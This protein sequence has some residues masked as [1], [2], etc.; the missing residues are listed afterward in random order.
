MRLAL[1]QIRGD[2]VYDYADTAKKNLTLIEKACA[3]KPDF[4]V[5]PECAYPSY[6][7]GPEK[8][9]LKEAVAG[10]EALLEEV[11]KLAKLRRVYI[12]IGIAVERE[13]RLYNAAVT[14][15][16]E[17][18]EIDFAAKTNLWHFDDRWFSPGQGYSAF[19]TE[20]G[21]I[22]T[23]ICADG[24]IPEIAGLLAKDGAKLIIDPVNLVAAAEKP[25]QLSNQQY[26]FILQERARENGLFI[27]VCDKCGVEGHVVT[28]LGRSFVVDPD[29]AMIEQCSS[30]R[31]EIKIVEIDLGRSR[32]VSVPDAGPF[33]SIKEAAD[34][35][36][37]SV[38]LRKN[39]AL[40]DL[41]LFTMVARFQSSSADEYVEKAV[42]YANNARIL[43]ARLL[44]LPELSSA[45]RLNET[46]AVKIADCLKEEFYAVLAGTKDSPLGL[47]RS[48]LVLGKSGIIKEISSFDSIKSA[49]AKTVE[50]AQLTESIRIGALFDEEIHN[51]WICRTAM[52]NGADIMVYFDT[53]SGAG[54]LKA[55]K[56]RA[57]ENKIFLVRS[58]SA[59]GA[60]CSLIIN[61][62]GA[63]IT[64]TFHDPEHSAA[65]YI[66]TA[67]SKFKSVVP[68]T[69]VVQGRFPELYKGLFSS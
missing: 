34:T 67:L 33:D 1:V 54:S 14:F 58:A 51:P 57:A 5:L 27:A 62:D 56:T 36:P 4:I 48:A 40:E 19:D 21:R 44:V 60:D 13:G 9:I 23:M 18:R 69:D 59:D 35:L 11:A 10:S 64:T 8:G 42:Y 41:A 53:V 12:C 52:L 25:E 31:E 32:Q 63:K 66:N 47:G 38:I 30:D 22:G 43:R 26:E 3:E 15:D 46:V 29:G 45:Y 68:G 37:V 65:A 7:I 39:Y 6:L 16:R 50:I 61:P 28:F 2:S 49:N 55:I 17:G 20:F 24:R